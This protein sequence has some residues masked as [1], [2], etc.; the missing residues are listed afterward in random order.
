MAKEFH[1]WSGSWLRAN[2]TKPLC[3]KLSR[4]ELRVR[5]LCK[6]YTMSATASG[7]LHALSGA[8]NKATLAAPSS[9]PT[10]H[11]SDENRLSHIA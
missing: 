11:I 2:K 4:D 5:D 1:A 10:R 3:V 9:R 8:V 6:L 7:S